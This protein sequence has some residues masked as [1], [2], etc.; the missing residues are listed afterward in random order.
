MILLV[1][2]L[3][4][5]ALGKLLQS[6][7]AWA[8]LAALL[9]HYFLDLFPH[10][11]Y[12]TSTEESITKLRTTSWRTYLPDAIKAGIDFALGILAIVLLA[13]FNP[14][15]LACGLI[16]VLPDIMTIITH[17]W[18]NHLLNRHHEI[19]GGPIHYLTKQKNFPVYWKIATQAIATLISITILVR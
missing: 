16:G 5:A 11:E 9:G 2:M 19:H 14:L 13:G 8:L 15:V 3:F 6:Y 10:I 18:P 17:L 4:G 12:L 7:P 1:H